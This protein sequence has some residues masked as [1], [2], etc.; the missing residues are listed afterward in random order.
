MGLRRGAAT[1][2][3]LLGGW[4]P[5]TSSA[6]LPQAPIPVGGQTDQWGWG[7]GGGRS[8]RETALSIFLGREGAPGTGCVESEG[9]VG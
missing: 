3:N 5:F 6:V 4:D 7:S 2:R 9:W 8:H 1:Q